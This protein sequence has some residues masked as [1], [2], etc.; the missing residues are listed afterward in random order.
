[1]NRK[2]FR[3]SLAVLAIAIGIAP[4][5]YSAV[6]VTP[7]AAYA[8]NNYKDR[9]PT[10]AIN[11]AG[12]TGEAHGNSADYTMWMGANS[13]SFAKWFVTD[14]GSVVPLHSMKIWN[15]NQSGYSGR[16]VKVIDIYISTN[17]SPSLS[18]VNF[19]DTATW[20]LLKANHTVAM[21]D[22]TTSYTGDA[23]LYLAVT[24]DARWVGFDIKS[25]HTL[26]QGYG[27]LSEV[28]FY[29]SNSP[30]VRLD[31]V[32]NVAATSIDIDGAM[33]KDRG[34]PAHVL[35]C[36]GATDGGAS[37][38]NW[39]VVV[40]FGVKSVG[41]FQEPLSGLTADR[42]YILALCATNGVDEAGWSVA[43]ET[44][45]TGVV[46]VDAPG[47]VYESSPIPASIV[48]SRPVATTNVALTVNYTLGG[49][50]VAGV[51]YETMSGSFTF[52]ADEETYALPFEPINNALTDGSRTVTVSVGVGN[53]LTNATSTTSFSILDD[54][55][56]ARSVTWTGAG[57]DLNW[58]NAANWDL[59]VPL[60]IDTAVFTD[61]GLSA[62]NVVALGANQTIRKLTIATTTAFTIGH[63]DDVTAGYS[64]TLTDVERQDVAGTEG[65]HTF[66]APVTLAPDGDGNS[67]WTINGS[68]EL[69]MN[70]VLG[71]TGATT[72]V[73]M[74]TGTFNMCFKSPTYAGPWQIVEGNI[75]ASNTGTMTGNATI[76]GT[77]V[78]ANLTQST[79]NAL[80]NN[81]NITV[82]TNGTF[83]AGD[84]DNGRVNSIHVKEG[85]V[86]TVGTYFY[87]LHAYLTGG[88]I[89]G[90][91][92][93]NGGWQQDIRSYASARPA[94]FNCGF[95]FSDYYDS[96]I[97]V[98][99]GDAIID[100]TVSKGMW[101]G[102]S[103]SSKTLT[104]SGSGMLRLTA[105]ASLTIGTFKISGGTV[106]A[107]NPSESATGKATVPVAAGATLGGTGTI[108][109][110]AG[111]TAANVTVAGAPGNPAVLAP[112]T[113][114]ETT[115]A[116][117]VGTLTVGGAA[118]TNNV[119]FGSHGKLR[120][121]LD[122]A[123]G[124]DRLAVNGVLSL[125]T[126]DDHL[127]IVV[128]ADAKAGVYLL[129]SATGGI[130]GTFDN[131]AMPAS[132]MSLVHTANTVELAVHPGGTVL[133]VR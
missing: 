73:K 88:T 40:D 54:E 87:C 70:A 90:G 125:A 15:Y 71:A 103:S 62:G 117:I 55:T 46:S 104:K 10:Y 16:G 12:L 38:D 44:F 67:T 113:I 51:D 4:F 30:V 23:V 119:T 6:P 17:A 25:I 102:G 14:L 69:R 86:A 19:A 118:Q 76:G 61:S 37:P 114:D 130:A 97:A 98:E 122:A 105:N 99:D 45:I 85:G 108:G 60:P 42:G 111:Y 35:A 74:G 24:V 100:L 3:S 28:K 58:T 115:G 34:V 68:G 29:S 80:Y 63:A 82:L 20:T 123:G 131:V 13:S 94:S 11:G 81:M 41:A 64:L 106:L 95:K 32:S 121:T 57:G 59:G 31:G 110:V 84:I 8:E 39:D 72:F 47:D 92:F 77:A 49:T 91:T 89:N 33:V 52:P 133:L 83:T 75:T 26:S 112:G 18:P 109:G 124:C 65:R 5:A 56:L 107:D 96:A 120:V 50:A 128:P 66:G 78:P 53:Y 21:A 2:P 116:H 43:Q 126:P 48:F 9:T 93:F 79:K 7:A 1:M 127:E 101:D 22:G 132:G 129:A 27:G 36:A